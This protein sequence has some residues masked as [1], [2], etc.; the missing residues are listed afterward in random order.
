MAQRPALQLKNTETGRSVLDVLFW[1]VSEF[2]P[3]HSVDDFFG[4]SDDSAA[5]NFRS[6][7]SGSFVTEER[8]LGIVTSRHPFTAWWNDRFEAGALENTGNGYRLTEEYLAPLLEELRTTS[9][10]RP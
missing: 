6:M 1:L 7:I 2:R 5:L 9:N 4:F 3:V 10:P 8:R